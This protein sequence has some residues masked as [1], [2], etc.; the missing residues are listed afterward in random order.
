VRGAVSSPHRLASEIGAQVLREG[1]NA[2]DAAVAADA[3]LCVIYPHMTSIGG[4]LFALVWPATAAAPYGLAGAGRS[5]SE[6][7]IEA[8]RA[9]GHERMP[10]RGAMTVTS[11]GTV[12]AWGRLVE[13]FGRL[14]LEPLLAPA[15]TLAED[16][17]EVSPGVAEGMRRT[18]DWRRLLPDAW[19]LWPS[20]EPGMTLRN[21]DLAAVLRSI[22]RYGFSA[23]ALGDVAQAIADTVRGE[24]GFLTP[25]D[26]RTRATWVTPI[27]FSYRDFQVW[28]MPPPTQGLAAAGLLRRFAE[29]RSEDLLGEPLGAILRR[30]RDTVYGLRDQYI[31]DPDFADAPRE[32]FLDP[33]FE[34][35]R[36]GE[37]LSDGDTIALTAV[38]E[39]GTL[40]SMI[41]SVSGS[42]GSGVVARGTGILLQNRGNYFSLDPA[43]VNRLEP[44]KRTMHTLIPAMARGREHRIAFGTMGGDGQPQL[45]TQVLL[46]LA[47]GGCSAQEAVA[48]PRIRAADAT[49]TWVEANHPH[50]RAW[51]RSLPG[52][53]P[54]APGDVSFG[55]A[56]AIVA[57]AD[58]TW[59]AGA[60]PRSDGAVA[61]SER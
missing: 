2:I 42:F 36:A 38:D 30:A 18:V 7:T 26:V 60:D 20:L 46:R 47:D 11:P 50:A 29:Y 34:G 5:G 59:D 14:G 17:W 8:V 49:T 12:E 4:D 25:D 16:G 32:P 3:A 39:E 43:H 21:P 52:A 19:A 56:T 37:P 15:A 35:A 44:H 58:G 28:E 45:Q 41:Q 51:L 10:E 24:G 9:A 13:R 57:T 22:G 40:V 1:G 33:S 27:P 48:A 61:R 54:L 55:H 23:F 53:V 6:A 31:T